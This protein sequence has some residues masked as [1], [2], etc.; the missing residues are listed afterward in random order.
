MLKSLKALLEGLTNPG[1]ADTPEHTLALAST[2]LLLEI[3]RADQT[4]SEAERAAV[5]A[6]AKRAF[7]LADRDV[8]ALLAQADTAVEEAVSLFDFTD[9]IN[10][11]CDQ[12]Q[13]RALVEDLWRIA[14][15]DGRLDRY[16]EYYLRKITDLLHVSHAT[17]IKAKFKVEAER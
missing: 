4:T 7:G 3:G 2:A 15:A 17:L 11:R 10:S 8:D 9:V 12:Q 14:Y 6:A 16:E 5:I 1:P 13:K